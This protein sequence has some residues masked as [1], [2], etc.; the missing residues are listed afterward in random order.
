MSESLPSLDLISDE[1]HREHDDHIRHLEAFEARAGILLGASAAL[2]AIGAQ[3]MTPA[4]APGVVAAVLA[5][6]AALWT[7]I[8]QQHPAWDT[9]RLRGY[10]RA[11]PSFT[12]LAM[13][14]AE[15][16][17]L[18]RIKLGL[19]RKRSLLRAAAALLALAVLI[20]TVATIFD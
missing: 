6:L 10:L 15:I 3:H 16:A 4:R 12:R 8:P 19:E 20:T 5:T 14:D 7:L 17:A 11:E 18:A 2:A 13:L 1:L 9:S